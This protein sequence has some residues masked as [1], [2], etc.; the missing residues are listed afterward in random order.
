MT[1]GD[2]HAPVV[3]QRRRMSRTRLLHLRSGREFASLWIKEFGRVERPAACV[4]TAARYQ[5][6]AIL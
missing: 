2:Q 5:Y 6:A 1:A 4:R 3:E